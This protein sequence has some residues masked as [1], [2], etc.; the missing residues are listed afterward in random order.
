M[1]PRKEK[2]VSTSLKT[3]IFEKKRRYGLLIS[4]T[5]DINRISKSVAPRTSGN[6]EAPTP[7]PQEIQRLPPLVLWHKGL[8]I[9]LAA[10]A[11]REIFAPCALVLGVGA[12]VFPSDSGW[13]PPDFPQYSCSLCSLQ[14]WWC[15]GNLGG[16]VHHPPPTTGKN[17]FLLSST[18][19]E[20]FV[21][22]FFFA[23]RNYFVETFCICCWIRD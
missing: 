21:G 18:L 22:L 11:A 7:R 6:L 2:T 13:E 10:T 15:A 20:S 23:K 1:S 9:S 4:S 5:A 8:H 17:P 12:S 14:A 3:T 16:A 19:S